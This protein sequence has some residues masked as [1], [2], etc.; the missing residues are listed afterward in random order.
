MNYFFFLP[1]YPSF[2]WSGIFG[3]ILDQAELIANNEDTELTLVHC[4]TCGISGKCFHNH[5]YPKLV[6]LLCNIHKKYLLKKLSRKIHL[7]SLSD[8]AKEKEINTISSFYYNSVKEIKEINYKNVEIGYAAFSTY[9]SFLARNLNPLIDDSFKVFFNQLLHRC[10]V[11]SDIVEDVLDEYSPDHVFLFNSRLIDSKPIVD[12]CKY[13]EISFTSLEHRMVLG[14]QPRKT[15]FENTTPHDIDRLTYLIKKQWDSSKLLLEEKIQIASTF[16]SNRK[17]AI[18][19]GDKVY[20]KNQQLGLLPEHW[21]EHKHNIVIFNSSEDEFASIGKS[22]DSKLLFSAQLDGLKTIFEAF[23]DYPEIVFYLRVHPNLMYV[24]Y[25]YHY[26]MYEFEKL[27]PNVTVIPADSPI[28]TYSLI[29]AANKV[30]VFGSTTGAESV[31]WGKPTILLG[32]AAYKYLDICYTPTNIAEVKDLILNFNLTIK[33]KL[34][35]LQFAYYFLN[36]E[37]GE[38]SF[39]K[40]TNRV[41]HFFKRPVRIQYFDIKG[42]KFSKYITF[43]TQFFC[44]LIYDFIP[45]EKT[46]TTEDEKVYEKYL[47]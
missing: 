23:K 46:P 43:L 30:I 34:G 29:D 45:K 27:Y 17:N 13:K 12:L 8:F 14:N 3:I 5:K 38:F 22:Y 20:V 10:C 31:F 44:K 42:S 15:F 21:N 7:L 19:A 37:S 9:L 11:F 33:D 24:N 41:Y 18:A 2:C 36:S 32:N 4:D 26:I 25:L 16:Y 35:A 28:S 47:L 6:C 40:V 39:F 1:H